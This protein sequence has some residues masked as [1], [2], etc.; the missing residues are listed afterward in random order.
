[1]AAAAARPAAKTANATKLDDFGRLRPPEGPAFMGA[2][3]GIS[4]GFPESSG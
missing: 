1:M 4:S 2:R 3:T